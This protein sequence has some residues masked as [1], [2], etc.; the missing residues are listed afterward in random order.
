[1]FTIKTLNAISPVGTKFKQAK[2]LGPQSQQNYFLSS[3]HAEPLKGKVY[4]KF[5]P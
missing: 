2:D 4:I 1:M 3:G 5:I